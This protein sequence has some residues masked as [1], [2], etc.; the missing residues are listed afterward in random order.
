[1]DRV[2]DRARTPTPP[3]WRVLL[4]RHDPEATRVRAAHRDGLEGKGRSESG[5]HRKAGVVAR[6]ELLSQ[7]RA[8]KGGIQPQVTGPGP[9][10]TR[11]SRRILV[12][13]RSRHRR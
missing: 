10:I 6:T 4:L 2:P 3:L 1:M 12:K 11:A 5:S 13:S 8:K 7:V 9:E